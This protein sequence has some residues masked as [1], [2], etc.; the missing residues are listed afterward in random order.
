MSSARTASGVHGATR[1][2]FTTVLNWGLGRQERTRAWL[3]RL[4][5]PVRG[6]TGPPPAGARPMASLV[7]LNWKRP[8]NVRRI[9]DR[10]V[11]CPAIDDLI[12]WNNNPEASFAYAHRNV[13]CINSDEFGLNTRWAACLLAKHACVLVHDDDLVCD[14]ATIGRLV[15]YHRRAPDRAYTLHGRNPTRSNEYA[16]KVDHV[17]EPTECDM[18]LTRVTCVSRR[19][20][21]RYFDALAEMGLEIDPARGGGE[22]IVF[23]YAARAA[24]GHRPVVVPGHYEDLI[25]R[26]AQANR[27]GAQAA[28]RTRIMRACQRWLEREHVEH[29]S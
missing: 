25:A 6:P 11:T 24:T 3:A 22:D 14:L 9:L 10:Y 19:W 13:R 4:R 18:H 15:E 1:G 2:L 12:V 21:P 29:A 23:S 7:V 27:A 26:H 16:D 28:E 17:R 8:D 5:D 20:V